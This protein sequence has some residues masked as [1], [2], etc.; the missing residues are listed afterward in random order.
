MSGVTPTWAT[1]DLGNSLYWGGIA[2]VRA[3]G[4]EVVSH[5]LRSVAGTDYR[6]SIAPVPEPASALLLLA[7]LAGLRM[8]RKS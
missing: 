7:G 4:A 5:A 1:F 3:G 2:S 6:T 8:R